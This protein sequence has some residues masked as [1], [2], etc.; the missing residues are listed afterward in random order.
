MCGRYTINC[1]IPP[2]QNT[3]IDCTE[4][5]RCTL[6][7]SCPTDLHHCVVFVDQVGAFHEHVHRTLKA[8]KQFMPDFPVVSLDFGCLLTT[9]AATFT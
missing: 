5:A 1:G 4:V 2:I 3:Q 7:V 9:I 8:S 6:L